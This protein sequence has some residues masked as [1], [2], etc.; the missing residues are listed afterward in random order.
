MAITPSTAIKLMLTE[1][2]VS[3]IQGAPDLNQFL[4][5]ILSLT[6]SYIFHVTVDGQAPPAC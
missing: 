5:D 2:A 6:S 3:Q 4:M 1:P